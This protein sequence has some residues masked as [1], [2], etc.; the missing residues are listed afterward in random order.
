MGTLWL[1]LL[2]RFGRTAYWYDCFA[3]AILTYFD[4][5]LQPKRSIVFEVGY[6]KRNSG[7]SQVITYAKPYLA[8]LSI[9]L[10][11]F[12]KKQE[13]V[14]RFG[15]PSK[16]FGDQL[17]GLGVGIDLFLGTK[18][19][20]RQNYSFGQTPSK[21]ADSHKG[22]PAFR[23]IVSTDVTD[24][25]LAAFDKFIDVKMPIYDQAGDDAAKKVGA[26]VF[27]RIDR[28]EA[29]LPATRPA[30]RYI[31]ATVGLYEDKNYLRQ[32]PDADFVVLF[33][34]DEWI[35]R[36]LNTTLDQLTPE[37][38][39]DVR[40]ANDAWSLKEF[41]SDP[42]VAT[43]ILTVGTS[44]YTAFK[45]SVYQYADIDVEA[46]MTTFKANLGALVS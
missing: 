20:G 14:N 2:R 6:L 39:A 40:A 24:A 28:I 32:I 3:V 29:A 44:M 41:L 8:E 19:I 26:V 31:A 11:K 42:D 4:R 7:M 17:P 37:Q 23:D 43:G 34:S 18:N 22:L 45:E 33:V 13:G 46:V 38:I 30:E 5:S 21:P 36:Q 16:V 25:W 35:A 9:N 10:N 12:K 27:P 15:A 1:R